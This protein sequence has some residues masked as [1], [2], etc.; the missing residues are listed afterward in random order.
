[1]N[2]DMFL[3]QTIFIHAISG[4]IYIIHGL[5]KGYEKLELESEDYIVSFH[6]IDWPLKSLIEI[7][8]L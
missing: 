6:A 5:D 1:M 8:D 4:N 2:T 7:G 3:K